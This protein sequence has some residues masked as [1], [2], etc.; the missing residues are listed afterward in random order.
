MFSLYN[1]IFI[2]SIVAI[3]S[4]LPLYLVILLY[5]VHSFILL[6]SNFSNKNRLKITSYFLTLFKNNQIIFLC[7]ILF[8]SQN[9]FSIRAYPRRFRFMT[10]Q[11][12]RDIPGSTDRHCFCQLDITQ[13]VGGFRRTWG[14]RTESLLQRL[15]FL[16][17]DDLCRR[18][19]C[20]KS[21]VGK[22]P[23]H[24][25]GWSVPFGQSFGPFDLPY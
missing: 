1:S 4:S 16:A 24:H 9:Y 17:A 12:Q 7:L 18:Q 2:S 10:V 20:H 14:Y 13:Q 3:Y 25:H 19:D 21:L 6:Y 22:H 5:I 15:I 23:R 11:I 8:C